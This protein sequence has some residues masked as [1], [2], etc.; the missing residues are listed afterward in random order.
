MFN[1]WLTN[2]DGE[3][4]P[5]C[6]DSVEDVSHFLSHCTSFIDTFESLWSNLSQKII[7]CNPS[8]GTQISRSLYQQF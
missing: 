2:T 5:F 7:A 8:D 6:K 4:S 3:L 1:T